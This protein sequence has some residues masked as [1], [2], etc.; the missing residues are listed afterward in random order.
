MAKCMNC[1]GS[2]KMG[3]MDLGGNTVNYNNPYQGM[4]PTSGYGTSQSSAEGP[5]RPKTGLGKAVKNLFTSDKKGKMP[6]RST[7]K[8]R[9]PKSVVKRGSNCYRN[10]NC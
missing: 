9:V 8:N 1:G 6:Q 5:W 7:G 4:E 3:Y 10:G 2:K